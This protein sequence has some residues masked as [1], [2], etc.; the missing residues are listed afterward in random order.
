MSLYKNLSLEKQLK[1]DMNIKKKV[2]SYNSN[3]PAV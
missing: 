2:A 3:G 1:F